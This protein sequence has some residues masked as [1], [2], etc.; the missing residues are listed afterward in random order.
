[1]SEDPTTIDPV[2]IRIGLALIT[3]IFAASLVLL[4]VV[5]DPIG[6]AIF[7][8]ITLVSLVRVILLVRWLKQDRPAT[9][10]M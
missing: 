5:Q 9:Q 10:P 8:C 4:I 3:V 6:R 2:K 1:V 7:F